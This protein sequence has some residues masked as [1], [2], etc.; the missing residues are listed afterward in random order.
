MTL[1]R[2]SRYIVI[3]QVW[4][5]QIVSH[6]FRDTNL[7][8]FLRILPIII[9]YYRIFAPRSRDGRAREFE[10]LVGVNRPTPRCDLYVRTVR[11]QR[12]LLLL[13]SW[14]WLWII[15]FLWWWLLLLGIR[16]ETTSATDGRVYVAR[17]EG[18]GHNTRRRSTVTV[19]HTQHRRL[20][21]LI[22]K[23]KKL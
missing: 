5:M 19:L 7:F 22:K 8:F 17:G 20:Q 2:G 3:V 12:L 21:R 6:K 23:N 16:R 4:R 9:C 1:G 15:M 18:Q 10:S 11:T 14:L 13:V